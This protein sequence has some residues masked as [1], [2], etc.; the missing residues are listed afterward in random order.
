MNDTPEASFR[1]IHW[2]APDG[3][4][5]SCVEKLKVLNDN[6]QEISSMCQDAFEDGLLMGCD[7]KQLREVFAQL[8]AGLANPYRKD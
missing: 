3:S 2:R 8:V 4:T 6:F 5:V 1:N 7:E